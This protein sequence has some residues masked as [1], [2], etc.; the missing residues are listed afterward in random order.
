MLSTH[1]VRKQLPPLRRWR[2]PLGTGKGLTYTR[3]G[4]YEKAHFPIHVNQHP[5]KL[6]TIKTR[7]VNKTTSAFFK[8]WVLFY[9]D[10]LITTVT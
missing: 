10:H 1:E 4:E 7:S 9:L 2:F 3:E 8:V 6:R 5:G